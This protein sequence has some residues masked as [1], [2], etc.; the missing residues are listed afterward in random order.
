MAWARLKPLIDILLFV[1]SLVFLI[2]IVSGVRAARIPEPA[3]HPVSSPPPAP[4]ESP[5]PSSI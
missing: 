1:A 4:A 2:A 3:T 5:A